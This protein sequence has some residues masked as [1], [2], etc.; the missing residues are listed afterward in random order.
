MALIVEIADPFP[1]A[2]G[3]PRLKPLA[4]EAGFPQMKLTGAAALCQGMAKAMLNQGPNRRVVP[5]GNFPGLF[6]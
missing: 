3:H 5:C 6:E 1:G 4:P 2:V